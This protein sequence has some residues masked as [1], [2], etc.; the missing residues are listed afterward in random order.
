[1]TP[2]SSNNDAIPSQTD[3]GGAMPAQW[4]EQIKEISHMFRLEMRSTIYLDDNK[5][6][7]SEEQVLCEAIEALLATVQAETD[8]NSRIDEVK[9]I[10]VHFQKEGLTS[11]K[12]EH[13]LA[14]L[15]Q[16]AADE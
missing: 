13:R 2:Q 10:K 12:F 9:R 3:N 4:R 14:A 6:R 8:R 11:W 16:K 5:E 7:K 1:M 15:N